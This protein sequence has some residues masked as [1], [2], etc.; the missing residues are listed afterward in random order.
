MP[1]QQCSRKGN[2]SPSTFPALISLISAVKA[3][4]W[5]LL[6]IPLIRITDEPVRL[7]ITLPAHAPARWTNIFTGDVFDASGPTLGL[8]GLL[9]KFPV[10][11]L[12]AG[13][14]ESKEELSL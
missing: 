1:V 11:M 4:D 6:I 12:T 13:T 3:G 14:A 8:D 9:D 5:V 10:A 7:S 2:I